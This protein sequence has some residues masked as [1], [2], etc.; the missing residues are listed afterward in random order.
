MTGSAFAALTVEVSGGPY[1]VNPGGEFTVTV[2]GST[3]GSMPVGYQFQSF[4]LERNETLT[5]GGTY[6]AVVNTAAV[7]GGQGGPSDPLSPQ[8][9][10]LYNRFLDGSLPGYDYVSAS[11][12]EDS[13][14]SLQNAIWDFEGE[15]ATL[16]G[17]ADLFQFLA[18]NLSGTDIGPVR[19]LNLYTD[20][21]LTHRAQD[22]LARP[23]PAPG[24]ILLV[25]LG[26]ACAGIVRRRRL[27]K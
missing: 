24:G 6:Y 20:A 11:G 12:H 18:N 19:V 2:T 23:V 7:L 22:I 16:D 13:A 26:S 27:V 9:A 5:L 3:I 4:C 10:W 14:E 25:A 1:Q 21:A 8:T 17:R 15:A